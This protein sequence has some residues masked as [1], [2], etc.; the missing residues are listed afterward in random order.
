MMAHTEDIQVID[1][2]VVDRE[3]FLNYYMLSD[4]SGTLVSQDGDK[5]SIHTNQLQ[6]RRYYA[7]VFAD[8]I[9]QLYHQTRLMDDWTDETKLP[10]EINSSD[11]SYPFVMTDGITIYF[12]SK[13]HGSIGGYD[14]FV[15]RYN[16]STD[17]FLEPEQ[18]GM[19]FNSI[20]NDYMLAIDDV[21]G[22]GFF[23][24][25]RFQPQGK[26]TIYTFLPNPEKRPV[27]NENTDYLKARALLTSIEA[28]WRE[29]SD[30][31]K[32]AEESRTGISLPEAPYKREFV[33]I[34]D[35]NIVYES[36]SDFKS[37]A[38][39]SLYAESRQLAG[40]L[41]EIQR[42]LTRY[43][44]DYASASGEK[45]SILG[46]AIL[47]M[48]KTL[49]EVNAKYDGSVASARNTEIKYLKQDKE[50]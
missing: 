45:R 28:T 24:T 33:F 5:I 40:K 12:A 21:S 18:L 44:F 10:P 13:G 31:G 23:A 50:K 11:T 14:L 41:S 17:A 35:D 29:G 9:Y 39:R 43:R 20:Y 47:E 8:S 6:N 37:D 3:S 38:A 27:D 36:L 49:D 22:I 19:P 30:Y 34:V 1:S 16:S 2:V 42:Q 46:A 32:M 15:S 7:K 4:E 26:V 25:D 48:E